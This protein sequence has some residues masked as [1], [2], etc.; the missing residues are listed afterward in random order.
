MPISISALNK[1]LTFTNL[2][3]FGMLV[4]ASSAARVTDIYPT[5]LARWVNDAQV[6]ILRGFEGL[7]EDG[8]VDF[9]RGWGD[10][11]RF[12]EADVFDLLAHDEPEHH[13][14]SSSRVPF[15]WDGGFQPEIPS[16]LA[17]Y[18]LQ[19]PENGIGGETIFC[20]TGRVVEQ[21]SPE[22]ADD[23]R[24]V[25]ITYSTGKPQKYGGSVSV[26]LMS[27]HPISRRKVLRFA[28]PLDPPEFRNVMQLS[29]SGVPEGQEDIF[30]AEMQRRI[31][32]P[33]VFLAHAWKDGDYGIVDNHSV[34]HGRNAFV[35]GARRW[36]KRVNIM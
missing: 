7:S 19:A 36:L 20:D 10:L 28:E 6:L 21:A 8:F 29:V 25:S 26:P 18:C 1:N 2:K 13:V 34:L 32:R 5:V 30:T 12:N 11:A 27:T 15:H 31:Y 3:P 22:L 23:W 16:Y 4:E 24:Q 9:C 17:F 14:F 35:P 33:D